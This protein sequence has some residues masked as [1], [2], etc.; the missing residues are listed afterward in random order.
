MGIF[1]ASMSTYYVCLVLS[2]TKESIGFPGTEVTDSC[3][4]TCGCRELN[5]HPLEE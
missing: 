5:P 1:S 4:V 2:W 3:D